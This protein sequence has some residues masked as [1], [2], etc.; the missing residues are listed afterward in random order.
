MFCSQRDAINLEPSNVAQCV[1][2]GKS[3]VIS[4]YWINT[5]S[6][7]NILIKLSLLRGKL[8]TQLALF[9][10]RVNPIFNS[11]RREASIFH[12]GE[13][14][15]TLCSAILRPLILIYNRSV[16]AIFVLFL[17]G[18]ITPCLEIR[19][20]RLLRVALL[21]STNSIMP[22]VRAIRTLE[23]FPLFSFPNTFIIDFLWAFVSLL[24]ISWLMLFR[25]YQS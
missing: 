9:P 13:L 18:Y 24:F 15:A 12:S 6:F 3:E 7:L 11:E 14:R 20:R 22:T 2:K 21:R 8:P 10:S 23:C 19:N 4:S 1:S 5:V 17:G 25:G 16:K